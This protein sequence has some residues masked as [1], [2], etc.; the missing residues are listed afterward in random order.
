[1]PAAA[2]RE[3]LHQAVAESGLGWIEV[4][5]DDDDGTSNVATVTLT[6]NSINDAPVALAQGI[7]H[8]FRSD[9]TPPF[10]DMVG[11]MFGQADPDQ[12]AVL[13]RWQG[14]VK[15]QRH[16]LPATG[17]EEDYLAERGLLDEVKAASAVRA[18][19]LD[20]LMR[21]YGDAV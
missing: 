8:S 14:M 4:V 3:A 15:P 10:A 16:S 6:V 5:R 17:L 2:P 19:R 1:M 21:L 18:T 9:R 20:G 7:A 12:R 13:Q 11:Q